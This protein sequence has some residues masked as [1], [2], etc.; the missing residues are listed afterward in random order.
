MSSELKCNIILLSQNICFFQSK[1]EAI[2]QELESLKY[3]C[4]LQENKDSSRIMTICLNTYI[5]YM[6]DIDF[7]KDLLNNSKNVQ[8]PS[9]INVYKY[10]KK[11]CGIYGY[12]P[13]IE[14]FK[15]FE[16]MRGEERYVKF[17]KHYLKYCKANPEIFFNTEGL[18]KEIESYKININQFK[19]KT[20]S[21]LN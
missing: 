10:D 8:Q 3:A 13:E 14:R 21:N 18:E 15:T 5:S 6:C 16:I 1:I 17:L 20:F 4:V 9:K 7:I 11:I 19:V 12:S 2:R